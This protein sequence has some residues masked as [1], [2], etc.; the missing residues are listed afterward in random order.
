M[1][2]VLIEH[3]GNEVV[4]CMCQLHACGYRMLCDAGDGEWERLER[5][6]CVDDIIGGACKGG[7]EWYAVRCL[8]EEICRGYRN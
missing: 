7:V 1:D 2:H 5:A 6:L 3:C 4:G 8:L